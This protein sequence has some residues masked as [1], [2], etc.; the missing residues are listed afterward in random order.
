MDSSCAK[1]SAI[2]KDDNLTFDALLDDGLDAGLDRDVEPALLT[3]SEVCLGLSCGFFFEVD[4]RRPEIASF[5]S[6]GLLEPVSDTFDLISSEYGACC[7]A[8]AEPDGE[9]SG[10]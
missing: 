10:G 1:L 8:L 7:N 2:V 9:C 4:L 6:L 3:S 5:G